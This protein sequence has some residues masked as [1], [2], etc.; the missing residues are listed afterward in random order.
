MLRVHDLVTLVADPEVRYTQGEN[1]MAIVNIRVAAHKERRTQENEPDSDFFRLTAF[2]KTAEN[3]AKYCTKGSKIFFEGK[4][5]NNNYEKDGQTVYNDQIVIDYMRLAG[6]RRVSGSQQTAPQASA[7]QPTQ[8]APAYYG[9]P[10]PQQP[11]QSYGQPTGYGQPMPQATPPAATPNMAGF[12]NIPD[13][14]PAVP[15][16]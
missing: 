7:P 4:L 5:Q 3:I 2:G 6:D 15:V 14:F 1:P 12:V 8:Q 11:M 16:A 10:M 13:G 9:Q